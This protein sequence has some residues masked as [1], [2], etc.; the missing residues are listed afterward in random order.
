M[1]PEQKKNNLRLGLVLATVAVAL[2]VGFM[3]KS[4]IFGI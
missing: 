4:A 3:V 1:T 2:F